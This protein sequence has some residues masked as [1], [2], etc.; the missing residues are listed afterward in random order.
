VK[1][2]V[3][4]SFNWNNVIIGLETTDIPFGNTIHAL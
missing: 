3:R 2:G 1:E 4:R